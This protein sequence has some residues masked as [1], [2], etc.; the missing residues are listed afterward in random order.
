MTK[1][2]G[3]LALLAAVAM[4]QGCVT[5][6]PVPPERKGDPQAA[7]ALTL[8]QAREL[9]QRW[10]R[11]H[12]G[13]GAPDHYVRVLEFADDHVESFIYRQNGRNEKYAVCPYEQV[14]PFVRTDIGT[15]KIG[16]HL[17]SPY[18]T[19]ESGCPDREN[20]GFVL[21]APTPEAARQAATGL[22]RW[23]LASPEERRERRAQE[24]RRFA[25]IAQTYQKS[26]PKPQLSEEALRLK[27]LAEEAVHA[28]R[29]PQAADA[30]ED[31]LQAAPWWPEGQ[32]NAALIQGQMRYYDEAIAHMKK[33]LTLEPQAP[34]ARAAQDQIYV[35][36]A[37]RAA[38]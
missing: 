12:F 7:A 17:G 27:A 15:F 28:K 37:S 13:D 31:A 11:W 38:L 26:Q 10:N 29:L 9:V 20:T 23:K 18:S 24:E 22:L 6:E 19:M 1:S 14:D 5:A 36:E 2:T 32:F 30:Y 35:W 21:V 33:Y 16:T 3:L 25:E 34:N 8:E 4:L